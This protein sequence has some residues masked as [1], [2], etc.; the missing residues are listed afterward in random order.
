M[1]VHKVVLDLITFYKTRHAGWIESHCSWSNNAVTHPG[2]RGI[3]ELVEDELGCS[4]L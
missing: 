2:D 1:L 3:Q 4:T